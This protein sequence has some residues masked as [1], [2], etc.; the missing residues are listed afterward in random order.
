MSRYDGRSFQNFTNK[1]GLRANLS[2]SVIQDREGHIWFGVY[3]GGA[4]RYDGK[5]IVTYSATDGLRDN[6]VIRVFQDREGIFWFGHY[7]GGVSR[8]DGETFVAFDDEEGLAG[9]A[10]YDIYRD[11]AG[12]LWFGT[13]Q[14]VSRYDGKTFTIYTVEDGLSSNE[15]SAIFQDKQG[16]MWFGTLD[17]GV[18][19]YDGQTFF[20]IAAEDGLS[21]NN[22]SAIVQDRIGNMWFSMLGGLSRYDGRNLERF[23]SNDD[24]GLVG[25]NTIITDQEGNLWFGGNRGA[26][27]FDGRT[28]TRFTSEE[29]LVANEVQALF[30]D[31]EGRMWF[32]TLAGVSRYNPGAGKDKK[33]WV[34]FAQE[35]GLSDNQ[36]TSIAQ[37]R[38]GHMW[39]GTG[40]GASRYDGK[41]FQTLLQK[42]GLAGDAVN[43]IVLDENGDV[44]FGTMTGASRFR[45]PEPSSP[46]VEIDAVVADRRREGISE[47]SI[48]LGMLT[49]A[50]EFHGANFRTRPEA[51]VYRYRLKDYDAD[52]LTTRKT[53][54]EYQDLPRG[55]FVFEVQAV[56]RDLVYSEAASVALNVHLPYERVGLWLALSL[57]VILLIAQGARIVRRDRRLKEVNTKLE[58]SNLAMSAANHELFDLNRDLQQEHALEHIRRE[59]QSMEKAADFHPVLSILA[60]DLKTVGLSFDSCA[61]DLLNEPVE[62]PTLE[63]F[64][65]NGLSSTSYTIDPEGQVEEQSFRLT[66]PFPPVVAET[67]KRF[68]D[69]KPWQGK[70]DEM[71]IVEVPAAGYGRLRLTASGRSD[72]SEEEIETLR[73]FAAAIALG[74]A[75]YLDIKT[76]QEQTEKKSAFLA[77]MSHELRTPMNAIKGFAN[78]VRRREP[79]ISDRGKENLEKV[80]QASDHLLAMINDLL[81]LS[82]IEAGRMDVNVSAFDVEKLIASC[83]GTV[84]P[85]VQDGVVLKYEVHGGGEVHTDEARV[86]QMVINLLSNAVKFTERGEVKVTARIQETGDRIQENVKG[87]SQK[88]G[89]GE[90]L[91]DVLEIAV[92]DTG[93]GIP[94][95]EVVTIFDE[96][97]QVKGSDSVVQKGTGLGLSITKKF[98]ELLGGTIRVESE[99]GKGS[100]FTVQIPAVYQDFED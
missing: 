54:V 38:D 55:D 75:R 36:V 23:A 46:S 80:D 12:H 81:D 91:A 7:G 76:I 59:V 61:I 67:L 99:E 69:G 71:A 47:L 68:A 64:E 26:T 96:Y 16:H 51:M 66:A 58:E 3:A 17:G 20:T 89:V 57:T 24:W 10:I 41:A 40:G 27:H 42:D 6:G 52:W 70:S 63:H 39:F 29:G 60:R 65:K 77:S 98:V 9:D 87:E 56:D 33:A 18:S 1:N 13:S 45:Q 83:V 19:R 5:T 32:G 25:V 14:G 90:R 43:D 11:R 95:D 88:P 78:L 31:R 53:R 28:F 8:Y 85:L 21:G 92:S 2:S 44:W 94:E 48:P 74:Y 72:F 79:G 93:Q 86:R 62:H 34:S 35:D 97:R 50:F 100:R 73:N 22:V 49:V 84:T 37:S 4:S 15:V 30:Q 82:K